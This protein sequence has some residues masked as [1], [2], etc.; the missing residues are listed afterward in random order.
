MEKLTGLLR[1]LR[2]K[3]ALMA[4]I[5][6]LIGWRSG[7]GRAD[8]NL[9]L[10]LF[11]PA[12]VLMGGNA[13]NDYFDVEI[14][15]VNRPDRPIPGGLVSRKEA[16][17]VYL[18]LSTLG[19][20]A[21]IR[22]GPWPLLIAAFFSMA[23]FLYAFKLKG[24]GLPGNALVSLGVGFTIIFGEISA[25]KPI[26]TPTLIYASVAFFT[27]L[28]REL[29][30]TVEDLSG[31]L[32]VGLRTFPVR[33]GLESTRKLVRALALITMALAYLPVLA[34]FSGRAY[35]ILASLAV[36]LMVYIFYQAGN[37]DPKSASR[38][39]GLIKAAMALGLCAMLA[40]VL[41]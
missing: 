17:V 2:P 7:Q 3:N 16:L 23:W 4:S 39:S 37:L 32:R 20:A 36:A 5:G 28:A 9:V 12:L 24:T 26:S 6:T 34:G 30:K 38:L 35:V 19:L 40:D 13:I 21:S 8:L 41:I 25:S 18:L 22:L 1:L 31:D 29:I 14:D 15:A 27:N 11:I 10:A 33:E